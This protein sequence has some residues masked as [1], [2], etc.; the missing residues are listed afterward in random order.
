VVTEEVKY[1]WN[2][3]VAAR[4]SKKLQMQRETHMS[5]DIGLKEKTERNA[6]ERK[7]QTVFQDRTAKI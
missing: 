2:A 4:S 1:I 6:S 5:K 3:A 7:R